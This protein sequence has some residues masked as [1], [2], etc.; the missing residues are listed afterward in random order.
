MTT[1]YLVRHSIPFKVH[2]GIEEIDESLLFSNM[3]T[4]LSVEGEEL[5][6]KVSFNDEF[7]DI[8]EVWSSD[9]VRAMSTAKYFA[10][11][12]NLKVNVSNKLG[13]RKHGINSWDELPSN[14]EIKQFEDENY[15]VGNG[16]SR[17]EVSER[18]IKKLYEIIDNKKNK[19]I[20]IVG[21][22]T[23]FAYLLSNWCDIKY[24]GPY[25]FKGKEFFDGKW[26]YC[27]SFKLVFD[28][29]NKLVSIENIKINA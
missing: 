16:E 10:Y 8:D 26:D 22:S 24:D 25:T 3:K 11:N 7:S 5:A 23:A 29:N 1:V 15:M 2:R 12:N 14:F 18:I 6:R 19:R 4:P 20:L 17:K 27:E 28:D 13:E 9:Y 21:H